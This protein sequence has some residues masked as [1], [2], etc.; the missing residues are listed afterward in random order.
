MSL[1]IVGR[2]NVGKS[3]LFNRLVGKRLAITDNFPGVTRD[4]RLE[5][6]HVGGIDLKL[7]DTAGFNLGGSSRIDVDILRLTEGAVRL[8]DAVLFLIDARQGVLPADR[9]IG[10]LLRKMARPVVVV[11]NKCEGSAGDAGTIEASELGFGYPVQISAERGDGMTE[12]AAEIRAA[13]RSGGD[14]FAVHEDQTESVSN[15]A[16]RGDAGNFVRIA[17]V[18][19]PNSGKSSLVNRIVGHERLLTGPTP[20]V[21]RDAISVSTTWNGMNVKIFDTAGMRKRAKVVDRLE[22]LSVSDGLR[23]VRFAEIVILLL[24]AEIPLEVQDLHIADLAEREGRSIVVAANK[25]DKVKSERNRLRSLQSTLEDRLPGIGGTRVVPISAL[26]GTGLDQLNS[27]VRKS[28]EIWNSRVSTGKLNRWLDQRIS[29]HPP[30]APQGRP[31]R[32][33]YITQ[34]KSRPPCFVIMCS[35]PSKLPVSYVRYL[36]NGLREEFGLQGTP[37]RIHLRSQG[38]KNPYA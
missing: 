2:P 20:G 24:D 32:L 13:L 6:V 3:T 26:N 28:L 23:A 5:H 22:R 16:N 1:A 18:G 15:P 35:H 37:I 34:A 11:A 38:D 30:P 7:I 33:R 29:A 25:W 4:F 31:L 8:A 27:E 10:N 12:L 14:E 17:V 21:T 9:E 19:R 36:K